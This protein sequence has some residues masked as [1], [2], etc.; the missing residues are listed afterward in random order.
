M[1]RHL[2]EPGARETVAAMTALALVVGLAALVV[3][4]DAGARGW[5]VEPFVWLALWAA[6]AGAVAGSALRGMRWR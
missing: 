1:G 4:A 6:I 3:L 2:A 5:S